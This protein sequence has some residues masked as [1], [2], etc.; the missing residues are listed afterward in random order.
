MVMGDDDEEFVDV[1]REMVDEG[2]GG[3][4]QVSEGE[5]GRRKGECGVR[6]SRKTERSWCGCCCPRY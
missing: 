5:E 4:R 3:D 1:A 6:S 2:D